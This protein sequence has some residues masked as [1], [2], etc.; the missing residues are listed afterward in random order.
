MK[1]RTAQ[2]KLHL[3]TLE[4]RCKHASLQLLHCSSIEVVSGS[5]IQTQTEQRRMRVMK[6]R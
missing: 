3:M 2:G 4:V 1:A 6:G 5:Q